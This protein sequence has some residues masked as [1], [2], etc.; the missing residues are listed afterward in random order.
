[1]F[2]AAGA[3]VVDPV[4]LPVAAFN[5]LVTDSKERKAIRSCRFSDLALGEGCADV[6][7]GETQRIKQLTM[8]NVPFLNRPSCKNS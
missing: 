6:D 1:M 8:A 2:F 4:R 3:R 5:R 7:S